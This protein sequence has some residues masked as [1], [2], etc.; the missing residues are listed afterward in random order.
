MYHE[1]AN[2]YGVYFLRLTL[3]LP[4][5]TDSWCSTGL[6]EVDGNTVKTLPD[7]DT[8]KKQITKVDPQG[9]SMDSYTPSNTQPRDCPATGEY[10]QASTN[11]PPTPNEGLC[12][13]MVKG[14]DCVAKSSVSDDSMGELFGYVCGQE[15]VDCTEILAN[16]TTGKYGEFSM[17]SPS[18]R[19]S[20]VLNAVSKRLAISS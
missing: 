7:F 11:L 13:C 18:E 9:V 3:V 6:V 15:G 8:L 10:W 2:N 20:W 12:Q 16:G 5:L 19:L 14:L 4:A 17:C 1:E